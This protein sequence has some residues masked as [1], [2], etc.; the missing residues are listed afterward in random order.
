[1]VER[2][3][4]YLKHT[5]SHGLLIERS[6]SRSLQA[7][8]DVDWVGDNLDR[9]STVTVSNPSMISSLLQQ[10]SGEFSLNDLGNLHFFLGVQATTHSKGLQLSQS[11]Y[12]SDLLCRTGM[13][14]CKPVHTPMASTQ[15]AL[16][17][18]GAPLCNPTEYHSIMGALQYVTLTCLDVAFDVNQACQFMYAPTF[19]HW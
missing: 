3:L 4:R 13:I 19:E 5:Y 10:L 7:F 17:A 12:I 9:K 14:D 18:G 16:D 15:K 11:W 6:A 1:M 2:I 8:S